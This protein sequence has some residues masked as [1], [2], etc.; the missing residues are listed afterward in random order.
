MEFGDTAIVS[1]HLTL[2][3]TKQTHHR[4]HL[5]AVLKF[6]ADSVE[7]HPAAFSISGVHVISGGKRAII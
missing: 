3:T 4:I 5:A 6:L 2:E 7:E 1:S